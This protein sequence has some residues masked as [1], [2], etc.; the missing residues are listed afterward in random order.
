M[1]QQSKSVIDSLVA[2]RK[3][4]DLS[5]PTAPLADRPEACPPIK[6]LDESSG[7][8]SP[9]KQYGG[10]RR[11]PYLAIVLSHGVI[12]RAF[13]YAIYSNT[14]I[15]LCFAGWCLLVALVSVHYRLKNIGY[16][17]RLCFLILVP[18]VNLFL[19]IRCLVLQEGY[20]ATKKLDT[21]GKIITYIV[22]VSVIAL[23]ILIGLSKTM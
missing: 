15:T 6:E 17:L 1:N 5:V 7:E 4:S 14:T 20:E 11:L 19:G 10:V 13:E 16:N 21:A 23:L 12:D 22:L 2:G 3:S 18:I 8:G 9:V